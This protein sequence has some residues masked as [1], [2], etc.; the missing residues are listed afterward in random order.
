MD[1]LTAGVL[2]FLIMVLLGAALKYGALAAGY[3]WRV[4]VVFRGAD[5]HMKA[6]WAT[7]MLPGA[8]RFSRDP[9]YALP[10]KDLAECRR[11]YPKLR[12]RLALAKIRPKP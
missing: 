5:G 12:F 2:S 7:A 11:R 8:V 3:E 1:W 9:R 10:A 6:A 4:M